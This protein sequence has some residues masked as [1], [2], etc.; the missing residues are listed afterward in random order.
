[1]SFLANTGTGFSLPYP[2]LALH[3]VSSSVP[4]S[5]STSATQCIYCQIDDAA[6]QDQAEGEDEDEDAVGLRQLWIVP[7]TN[8][9]GK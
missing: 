8:D 6:A 3:A 7:S 4:D 2:L 1:M 9:Q 5:I